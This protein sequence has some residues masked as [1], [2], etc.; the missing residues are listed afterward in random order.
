LAAGALINEA[1]NSAIACQSEWLEPSSALK[2]L[3]EH[4]AASAN[5]ETV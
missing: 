2:H 1:I 3:N 5:Y 4:V